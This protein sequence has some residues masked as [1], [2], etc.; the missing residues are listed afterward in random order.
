MVFSTLPD[1]DVW[2]STAPYLDMLTF[3]PVVAL[4]EGICPSF[5]GDS[6]SK[7]AETGYEDNDSEDPG[8]D[9]HC[10]CDCDIRLVRYSV[11]GL[12][13]KISVDVGKLLVRWI[14]IIRGCRKGRQIYIFWGI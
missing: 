2:L 4:G 11:Q 9:C 10:K 5:H 7:I 3:R 1:L 12:I 8:Y 13:C 14:L 6:C